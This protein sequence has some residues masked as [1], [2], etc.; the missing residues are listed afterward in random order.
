MTEFNLCR[1]LSR[2]LAKD[3]G[4][5]P[6]SL[7]KISTTHKDLL[8]K[9]TLK[10]QDEK[11]IVKNIPMWYGE[12]QGIEGKT[13]CLL[14]AL[15]PYLDSLE[16]AAVIGF[17][18]F[19]DEFQKDAVR[20]GFRYDWSNDEDKGTLIVKAGEQ[21]IE[22]S[23]AQRLQLALGFEHMVQDGVVWNPAGVPEELRKNLSEIIEVDEEY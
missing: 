5:T 6:F 3:L 20:V 23:L 14:A 13:C 9:S 11:G 12:A 21:W 2:K 1:E 22:V 8:V 19:E 4:A 18:D 10:I 16:F 17:K 7:G 15:D